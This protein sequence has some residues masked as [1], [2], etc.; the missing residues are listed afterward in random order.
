MHSLI[1]DIGNTNLKVY[2]FYKGQIVQ[3]QVFTEDLEVIHFLRSQPDSKK[4]TMC[5]MATVREVSPKLFDYLN[6][7]FVVK[8]FNTIKVLP[9]KMEYKTPGTLGQD[10]IA[11][12]AGA[13]VL[14]PGSNV[15]IIDAGTAITY[16]FL[17]D[18]SVY[19]GGT[20]SPGIGI[21]FRALHTFTGKL[22]F[23][24]IDM[25]KSKIYGQTT[26]D[27]ILSG[28][29]NG[30][31]YEVRGV[32][33]SYKRKHKDIKVVLTGGYSF[34]FEKFLKFRIF[35]TPDLTAIGL[36]KILEINV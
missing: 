17:S 36:N 4:I 24:D 28:V 25:N 19:Y 21:R 23:L 2:F 6:K 16:D 18:K 34:F 27:A 31:L 12:V 7:N 30:I 3:Q 32:I 29:Q 26:E 15:L 9:F 8:S 20:I 22:P 10:R 1:L 33:K 11:A 14:F 5:M 13:S 35:A